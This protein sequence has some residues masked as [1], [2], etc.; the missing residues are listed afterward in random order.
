MNDETQDVLFR[1]IVYAAVKAFGKDNMLSIPTDKLT[2][3]EG[4]QL[5]F[6]WSAQPGANVIEL[7]VLEGD[8]VD[9][10]TDGDKIKQYFVDRGLIEKD[11]VVETPAATPDT[12]KEP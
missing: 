6:M 10:V 4:G 8:D 1:H 2:M 12:I 9:L 3:P 5:T 7:V 11:A